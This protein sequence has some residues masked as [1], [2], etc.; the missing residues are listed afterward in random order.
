MKITS[1]GYVGINTLSPVSQA[2]VVGADSVN[3]LTVTSSTYGIRLGTASGTGATIQAVD[4]TGVASLQPLYISGTQV[5]ISAGSGTNGIFIAPSGNVGIGTLS[6]G[7]RLDVTGSVGTVS[8]NSA[9]DQISYGYNGYNFITAGGAAATLQIQASG[10]GGQITVATNGAERIRVTAAGN[11]G[12]G[13]SAPAS[14]L[15]VNYSDSANIITV[16]GASYGVRIGSASGT[17]GT[18]AGVDSTG[19]A[20]YQPLYITGTQVTIGANG[21]ANGL[22]VDSNANIYPTSA[23]STTMTNGFIYI[24]GASGVPTGTPTS[25]SGRVA[26]YYDTTGHDFWVYD[27]LWKKVH[28]N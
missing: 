8:V 22:I 5:T 10:V 20:S 3:I 2:H 25:V 6:P 4:S 15:H 13:T 28:L 14:R 1:A 17:G 19:V 24:P 18:I 27:G 9:G 12:I 23:V 16:T 7:G 26:M 21:G 11:V